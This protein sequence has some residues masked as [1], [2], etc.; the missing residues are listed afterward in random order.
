MMLLGVGLPRLC[1][2]R[3]TSTL[4]SKVIYRPPVRNSSLAQALWPPT[5]RDSLPIRSFYQGIVHIMWGSSGPL[6]LRNY[7]K[8]YTNHSEV[9]ARFAAPHTQCEEQPATLL[10]AAGDG[11]GMVTAEH[12]DVTF[13]AHTH[14]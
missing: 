1:A 5:T 14:D 7:P 8:L 4:P 13:N 11:G 2:G 6:I 10:L 9:A 3:G 12:S